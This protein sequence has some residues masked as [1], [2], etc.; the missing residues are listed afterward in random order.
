MKSL[1]GKEIGGDDVVY[2]NSNE[3]H[4]GSFITE[5]ALGAGYIHGFV[6][7]DPELLTKGINSMIELKADQVLE[8]AENHLLRCLIEFPSARASLLRIMDVNRSSGSED[9]ITWTRPEKLWLFRRLT[10][11]DPDLIAFGKDNLIDFQTFLSIQQDAFPGAISQ[12]KGHFTPGLIHG[13]LDNESRLAVT[14]ASGP[15][16]ALPRDP[17]YPAL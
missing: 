14:R 8:S 2:F 17:L 9:Q 10:S 16:E 1:Q 3:Y 12:P 15:T 4:G 6:P 7:R 5:E 13:S 11:N